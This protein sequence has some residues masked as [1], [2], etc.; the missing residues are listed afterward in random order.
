MTEITLP[1]GNR[2]AQPAVVGCHDCGLVQVTP[3]LQWRNVAEC[4][5][6]GSHLERAHLAPVTNPLVWAITGVILA[7]PA[8]LM[9]VFIVTAAG[10]TR[11]SRADGTVV[12]LYNYDYTPLSVV[13]ALFSIL[14]PV[15]WLGGLTTVLLCLR[16]GR[17]PPWLGTLF[18]LLND[19]DIWAMPDVFVM[20][21]FVAYTR[22]QAVASVEIGI[23]GWAYLG[24]AFCSTFVRLKLDRASLWRM[25]MPD[26][27]RM[28]DADAILCPHCSLLMKGNDG[29]LCPRCNARI[30]RRKPDALK[31]CFALVV[32]SYLL[33]IPAN[34]LPVLETV[35]FGRSQN[36]TIFAGAIELVQAGMWPLAL[37]VMMASI[38]VPVMK[39]FGLTWFMLS[40]RRRSDVH[41]KG[42]TRFYRLIGAIGRWSNIDVFMIGLLAS[43]VEFG[44]L[45]TIRPGPGALAFAAVVILTMFASHAFDSRLMW[46]AAGEG[47]V[48]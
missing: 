13:M 26:P 47:K 11:D 31:R 19:L 27:T 16:T 8:L 7:F 21:G 22:L 48:E 42:R 24:M 34:L 29:E 10:I 38:V 2:D 4:I 43:L 30:H 5:R 36:H 28:P 20:G 37:I 32:A 40:I 12:A 35:R 17:R 33:Y 9:P 3:A 18:R 46:D 44:N 23:G 14:F 41:I 45:T 15:I 1:P 25:L 39:L 6:C